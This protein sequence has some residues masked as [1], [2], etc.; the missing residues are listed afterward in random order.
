MIGNNDNPL[1]FSDFLLDDAFIDRTREPEDFKEYISK[2]KQTYPHQ[3][4]NID[5]AV[6]LIQEIRNIPSSEDEEKKQQVWDRISIHSAKKKRNFAFRIAATI[7]VL[8]GLSCTVLYFSLLNDRNPIER[9]AAMH[10]PSNDKSRLILAEGQDIAIP[11]YESNVSYSTTGESITISDKTIMQ[12]VGAEDFNQI[13]VPFGKYNSLTLSD[14]TKVWI[15]ANSRLI[16][17]PVFTGKIREVFIQGEAYFEVAKDADRPFY[18]KTDR[19]QVHVHGT[20]FNIQANEEEGLYTTL[21]FEGKVSVSSNESNFIR[22]KEFELEPGYMAALMDDKRSFEVDV[23]EHLDDYIAWRNGYLFF[24]EE[25]LDELI[26]RVSRY[27]DI[28]VQLIN[29]P[30]LVKISGKLDLKDDPERVLRGISTIAKCRLF[31]EEGKCII[32]Q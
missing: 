2:L 24:N 9:F 4:K 23:V 12:E 20:K 22:G 10:A 30:K 14:G 7:L 27:Y 19:F 25:P 26:K 28:D 13:I 18:V 1:D 15:N 6:K 5:V 31:Y 32:T 29:A 21:L 8:V 17:P 11:D 3:T 16:F